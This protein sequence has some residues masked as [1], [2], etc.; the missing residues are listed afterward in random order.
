MRKVC[1]NINIVLASII[2]A[3]SRD[4]KCTKKETTFSF[5]KGCNIDVYVWEEEHRFKI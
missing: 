1:L 3:A 4:I 5:P 2:E